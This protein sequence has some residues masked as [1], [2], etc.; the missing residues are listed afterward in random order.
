MH[1][2]EAM[3]AYSRRRARDVPNVMG[4][5]PF[6]AAAVS[7][8]ASGFG[9]NRAP[10]FTSPQIESEVIASLEICSRPGPT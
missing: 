8:C 10:D 6:M 1:D 2:E 4:V 5:T 9:A 3:R 7:A